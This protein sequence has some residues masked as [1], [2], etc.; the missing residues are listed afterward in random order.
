[1]VVWKS[2]RHKVSINMSLVETHNALTPSEIQ[3]FLPPLPPSVELYTSTTIPGH[4]FERVFGLVRD[5]TAAMYRRSSM[6][7][8]AACKRREM[9]HPAMRFLVLSSRRPTASAGAEVG[10]MGHV[11]AAGGGGEEAEA[12]AEV[13]G[14]TSFMVT[15]EEGEEVIYWWVRLLS[16]AFSAVLTDRPADGGEGGTATSCT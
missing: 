3:S 8:N 13:E 10:R 15:E 2:R 6:G 4:I 7:W 16:C 1:M 11:A 5:N 12:E 9:R 14:F